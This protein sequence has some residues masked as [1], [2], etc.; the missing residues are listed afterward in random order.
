MMKNLE[1]KNGG[2]KTKQKVNIPTVKNV[3][4]LDLN[5]FSKNDL[6]KL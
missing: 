2:T 4:F 1:K 6:A 3:S 5:S